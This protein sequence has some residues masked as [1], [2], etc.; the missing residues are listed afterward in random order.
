VKI[1]QFFKK[2][3]W[4]IPL[5]KKKPFK[6]LLIRTVRILISTASGFINDQC[7]LQA[8]AL[9]YYSLLSIVPALAV[10]FGIAK[11]FG[12]EENLQALILKT[13]KESPE[14]AAKA[15]EFTY[16]LLE[17]TKGSVIAG[18]GVIVLF[19]TVV[20]LLESTEHAL[21]TIWRTPDRPPLQKI[22][23]YLAVILLCP[24][25]FVT[26]SSIVI[27]ISTQIE[28]I[29]NQIG[30]GDVVKP[31]VSFGLHLFSY[32]LSW[33]LF[34]FIYLFIPNIHVNWR[35]ALFAGIVA[36]TIY[37]LLQ[38]AYIAFQIGV[39]NY[40]AIYGSFAALPLF[41]VWINLS[42]WIVLGGAEL[43]Y[44]AENDYTVVHKR[45]G[46]ERKI[47]VSKHTLALAMV[48]QYI[49]EFRKAE[50]PT[51]LK[52]LAY[53]FGITPYLTGE[54]LQALQ[55]AHILS[56]VI[57]EDG[58]DGYLPAVPPQSITM[59]KV[60]DAVDLSYTDALEVYS[61]PYLAMMQKKVIALEKE[62]YASP[63]NVSFDKLRDF[64][65][66]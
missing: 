9:T 10:A 19:W 27:Y 63:F 47:L 5:N 36:G 46:D 25:F 64:K 31:L 29:S 44:H 16:S 55:A 4:Q 21:N 7:F 28:D 56:K 12:F 17:Q 23:D 49:D 54:I 2:D 20:R 30:Y 34:Y 6:S 48:Y 35:S 11:G 42:W 50:P 65:E 40:G 22:K 58:S 57:S 3:F 61:N 59:K 37:Q 13:F 15:I 62:T 51:S 32:A 39:S 1:A 53:T 41:L 14:F 33:L 66:D 18:V 38:W 24:I 52:K 8:S 43:S 45:H 26:A 60:I